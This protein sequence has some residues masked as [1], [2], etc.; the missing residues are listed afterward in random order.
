MES[1]SCSSRKQPS[2]RSESL[3]GHAVLPATVTPPGT[4]VKSCT[5]PEKH[6]SRREKGSFPPRIRNLLQ[7]G[8][9]RSSQ[10]GC[11]IWDKTP[12]STSWAATI[13]EETGWNYQQSSRV[14][15][16]DKPGFGNQIACNL[17]AAPRV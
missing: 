11:A 4:G 17:I 5:S 1:Q 13:R 9:Y 3:H 2:N 8:L 16:H 14:T 15:G 6:Q 12:L 10:M 7:I